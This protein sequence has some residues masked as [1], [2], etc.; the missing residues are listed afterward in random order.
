MPRLDEPTC[1]ERLAAA[2]HAYLAT[3]DGAGEPHVVPITFALVAGGDELVTA[4]DHKP[5]ST[6]DLR[7]LRNIAT[8]PRVSVLV[9]RYDDDWDGLWW[10]RLDGTATVELS[11]S[12]RE[13]ALDALAARYPQYARRRPA[14][15]L[16]RVAVVRWSGWAAAGA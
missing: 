6:T 9:D 13:V 11:G 7:R 4:V 2:R 1:R 10:V 3:A 16:L 8:N 5:K 12:R 15:P 14:G